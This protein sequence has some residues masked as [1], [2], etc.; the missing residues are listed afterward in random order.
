MNPDMK[1]TIV[2]SEEKKDA[3]N[4]ADVYSQLHP[5]DYCE[6][7]NSK[8]SA[9]DRSNMLDAAVA[10]ERSVL[11]N[12]RCLRQG[13]DNCG[14][15]STLFTRMKESIID[16][17]Q[18]VGRVL[19]L[20]SSRP[21]KQATIIVPIIGEEDGTYDMQP[22]LNVINAMSQYDERLE[23]EIETLKKSESKSLDKILEHIDL[24]DLDGAEISKE[25]ILTEVLRD[26]VCY[27]RTDVELNSLEDLRT[28]V[29]TGCIGE[30]RYGTGFGEN[31]PLAT[32]FYLQAKDNL[33]IIG[34][35]P[36]MKIY[37]SL[38]PELKDSYVTIASF[39]EH[40]YGVKG[41]DELRE[42][43]NSSDFESIDELKNYVYEKFD[44][45]YPGRIEDFREECLKKLGF[46]YR[47]LVNKFQNL[48]ERFAKIKL[49]S[50]DVAHMVFKNKSIDEI[51][52]AKKKFTSIKEMR[53]E[54]KSHW[55][56][57]P[58]T[59]LISKEVKAK[60]GRG[61]S[62]LIIELKE[63]LANEKLLPKS[64]KPKDFK[65]NLGDFLEF[66]YGDGSDK[67]KLK[68][69]LEKKTK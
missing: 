54:I 30:T 67:D 11:S 40:I 56:V 37:K 58:K 4:F 22:L 12:A 7:L 21:D 69:I 50:N 8:F 44:G 49:N 29:K 34:P 53:A 68:Q 17:I 47:A 35:K 51:L 46:G 62:S 38:F 39:L 28:L 59:V 1:H 31:M 24:M 60:M 16:I 27:A 32:D 33:K 55:Q 41:I 19:R 5:D 66:M 3:L 13:I 64:M 36:I 42:K 63:L 9:A 65:M 15:D 14:F 48:D 52:K 2:F 18:S 25:D 6:Y 26:T 43:Q 10:S 57:N 45:V 20:D 61:Y 23:A